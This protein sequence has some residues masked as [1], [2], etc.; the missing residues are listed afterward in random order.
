MNPVHDGASI[1]LET[2]VPKK[3]G[4]QHKLQQS[5]K[6]LAKV[7]RAVRYSPILA[8]LQGPRYSSQTHPPVSFKGTRAALAE[9]QHSSHRSCLPV[10]NGPSLNEPWAY[11]I[12]HQQYRPPIRPKQMSGIIAV[13]WE[14][15]ERGE[16]GSTSH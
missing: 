13:D 5:I 8:L 7:D 2:A 9:S 16:K 12:I 4:V 1:H 3:D 15:C 6:I 14:S 11:L 10:D